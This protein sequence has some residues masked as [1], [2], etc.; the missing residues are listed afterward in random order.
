[1]KRIALAAAAALGL[2]FASAEAAT[3]NVSTG[4]DSA[5]A[6]VTGTGGIDA[7]WTTSSGPARTVSSGAADWFVAWAANGPNSSWIA[8]DPNSITGNTTTYERSFDLTGFDV[9]T[10]SLSAAWAIDDAGEVR[11]NGYLLSTL[12]PGAWGSLTSFSAGSAAFVAGVNTLTISFTDTDNYLEA[13]RLEGT[14]T[15]QP[16]AQ[17][18]VPEPAS[19]ALFGFA[20]AGLAATKRRRPA[21]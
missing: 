12:A 6:L 3:I 1:M 8:V 4:F 18:N 11:L 13:V 9:T 20:L 16:V 10:A 21:A 15:V 2:T 17:A 19:L 5:G 14:V 7:H